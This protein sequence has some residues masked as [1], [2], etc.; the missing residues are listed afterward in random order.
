MFEEVLFFKLRITEKQ[1]INST[2]LVS[3][4]CGRLAE[5][6]GK[7][8]LCPFPSASLIHTHTHIQK[9]RENCLKKKEN[10]PERGERPWSA[11]RQCSGTE[12][13]AKTLKQAQA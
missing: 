12:L 6:K 2:Y 13:A 10:I 7:S 5:G 3:V 1:T 4:G 9:E 11:H 8:V